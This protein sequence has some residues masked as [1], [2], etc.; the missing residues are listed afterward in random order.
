MTKERAARKTWMG[1]VK[2]GHDEGE[3]ARNLQNPG[4][5]AISAA[6][7]LEPGRFA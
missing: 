4:G 7:L 6:L 2:P 3:V 1:R 5:A